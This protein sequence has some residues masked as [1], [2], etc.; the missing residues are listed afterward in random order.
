MVDVGMAIRKSYYD[1][2]NGQIVIEGAQV[3]IVDEKLDVDISEQDIYVILT[4]QDEEGSASNKSRFVNETLLRM[5]IVNQRRAT[6]SKEVVEDVAGQI[7]EILFPTRTTWALSLASPLH[8]TSANYLGGQYNPIAQN[9]YGFFI[10]K[11][12][13]FKNRITQ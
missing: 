10:S 9:E 12:L 5:Q 11:T 7:L 6:G 4:S 3:P 13:T 8:L 1:A 2:L